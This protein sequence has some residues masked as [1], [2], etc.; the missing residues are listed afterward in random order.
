MNIIK[1]EL[2]E[3]TAK[4]VLPGSLIIGDAK[5]REQSREVKFYE[6]AAPQKLLDTGL[7]QI[8]KSDAEITILCSTEHEVLIR[9]IMQS[10]QSSLGVKFNVFVEAVDDAVLQS[11]INAGE[12]QMA[13]APITY[14]SDTAFSGVLRYTS[15]SSD[16]IVNLKSNPYDEIVERIKDA[17]GTTAS[18]VATRQAENFLVS[19][20]VI[21]PLYEQM[22]YFGLGKGVEGITFNN[23]GE[24]LY[25][26]NTVVK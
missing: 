19:S 15:D 18:T 3:F 5:Y 2:G 25:F 9:K 13:F 16:N 22:V 26:K 11:R 20:C 7:L 24:I 21:I 14:S 4:G 6:N 17:A 10:W 12:Y 23:T 8:E 1:S